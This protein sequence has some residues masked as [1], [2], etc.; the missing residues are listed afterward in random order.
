MSHKIVWTIAGHDPCGGGGIQ[1][2]LATFQD[3]NLQGCAIPTLLTVQNTVNVSELSFCDSA[4]VQK[5]IQGLKN[6]LL[7]SA[8]KVGALGHAGT[9]MVVCRYFKEYSGFVVY[10]PALV[11]TSGY[12]L[13]DINAYDNILKLL[14]PRVDLFTPN[15][16]EASL[17]LNIPITKADDMVLAAKKFLELG[18]RRVLIKGGHLAGDFVHDYFLDN[19][20]SF[21]LNSHWLDVG[22]VRGTGCRLSSALTACFVLGEELYDALIRARIYLQTK[23]RHAAAMGQGAKMM[24]NLSF[25][26]DQDDLPW[27]S[28]APMGEATPF[29]NCGAVPLGL[30]PVVDSVEWVEYLL[31]RNV[32][33]IQLRIKNK[34][35]NEIEPEIID[36]IKLAKKYQAQLFINDYW[37]LAIKHQAY[38]VHLGQDALVFADFQAIWQAGLRLGISTHSYYEMAC[39]HA[40]G[41]SY[42]AFGTI[43]FTTSKVMHF[44]PQGLARLKYWCE[45]LHYPVV[46]IGGINL[47]NYKDVL[48]TGV[49]GIALISAITKTRD[50]EQTI[51]LFLGQQYVYSTRTAT[52]SSSNSIA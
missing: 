33:T 19:Q 15:I 8:I 34:S 23:I 31:Q 30:Y 9:V 16:I 52:L 37:Q 6:D 32:K 45:L 41:P 21:W 25:A 27:V 44:A 12:P 38:G 36:S 48:M 47:Q 24:I 14:L 10:D 2:D 28:K 18:C 22:E 50:P 42:V 5:Q 13:T 40:I 20:Q 11:A 46:A 3:F 17:L 43:F 35:A 39:A 7:P 26:S 4:F 51:K 1:A 29:L 49:N